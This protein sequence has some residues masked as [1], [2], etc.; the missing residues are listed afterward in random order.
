MNIVAQF[1]KTYLSLH[2]LSVTARTPSL[3]AHKPHSEL[4]GWGAPGLTSYLRWPIQEIWCPNSSS[5]NSI[6]GFKGTS[7]TT[8]ICTCIVV[9]THYHS[10]IKCSC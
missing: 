2:K 4:S 9:D 8:H 1:L 7:A 10:T 5:S 3:G 6:T